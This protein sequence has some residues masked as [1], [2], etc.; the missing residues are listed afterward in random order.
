MGARS[1]R[2]A[3]TAGGQ[4]SSCA[5]PSPEAWKKRTGIRLEAGPASRYYQSVN[6]LTSSLERHDVL[7]NSTRQGKTRTTVFVLRE[8]RECRQ[9]PHRKSH[10]LPLR[11]LPDGF[12]P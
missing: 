9:E 3:R 1:R 10:G 7:G 2:S 8:K 5:F 12:E 11:E 4:S 6:P